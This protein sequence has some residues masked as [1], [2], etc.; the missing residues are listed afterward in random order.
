M[1]NVLYAGSPDASAKTLELLLNDSYHALSNDASSEATYRIVG[2]L[3]NPPSAQGRHKELIPTDVAQCA[4]KWNETHTGAENQIAIFTPE[5]LDGA[6]REEIEKVHADIVVCFAYGHI[7]G[8]K[9]LAL[10]KFGGI[11]LHPSLLPKYRGCTPVNAAL[12]NCDS[13]TGISIQKLALAADEGDLLVQ[14]TIP[15][16]GKE[17]AETL[18]NDSAEKGALFLATILRFTAEHN[19]LPPA[20]PQSGEASYCPLIKKEDGIIDWKNPAKKIDA[21]IRAYTPWP[22]CFTTANG[23]QLRILTAYA[24]VSSAADASTA[25][26]TAVLAANNSTASGTTV[27]GTV[28][29]FDKPRGIIIQCGEGV[30]VVQELQWQ[31]KKAMDY[32]S[33]MNGARDFIGT[34]LV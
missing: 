2:V 3:T 7:F 1:L 14:Q 29:A 21:Q 28:V 23:V 4:M 13:E 31:A 6:C 20:T 24:D 34:V 9:F 32:K 16:T 18:L 11:N 8:P 15:L 22:G 12:L 5:H 10:F 27:P 25:S 19:E 26:G 33:F 17:T 30:L